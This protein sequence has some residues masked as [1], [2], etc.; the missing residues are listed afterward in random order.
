MI[1]FGIYCDF[2]IVLPIRLRTSI[3]NVFFVFF[4]RQNVRARKIGR[5]SKEMHVQAC[6]MGTGRAICPNLLLRFSAIDCH[7]RLN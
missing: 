2:F 3:S 1:V 6:S 5:V 7:F 4:T